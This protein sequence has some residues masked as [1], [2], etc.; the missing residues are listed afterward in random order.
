MNL[1]KRKNVGKDGIKNFHNI[2]MENKPYEYRPNHPKQDKEP[3]PGPLQ[4]HTGQVPEDRVDTEMDGTEAVQGCGGPADIRG[5]KVPDTE[6]QSIQDQSRITNDS[7][8][9]YK[10]P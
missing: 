8:A 2:K 10:D 1:K 9:I 7:K 5:G 6:L 4:D 3:A